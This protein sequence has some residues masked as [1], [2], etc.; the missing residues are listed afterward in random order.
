VPIQ[1]QILISSC[2]CLHRFSYPVR[3]IA[4]LSRITG[5]GNLNGTFRHAFLHESVRRGI[6][7]H[8][9]LQDRAL[10]L[11][12]IRCMQTVTESLWCPFGK[13]WPCYGSLASQYTKCVS[14]LLTVCSWCTPLCQLCPSEL[15]PNPAWVPVKSPQDYG[16]CC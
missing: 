10:C 15:L 8:S 9:T 1:S 3:L 13:L 12:C 4:K 7:G 6:W 5:A 11:H 16:L 14:C 2:S